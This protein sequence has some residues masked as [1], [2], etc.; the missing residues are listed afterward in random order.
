MNKNILL[1]LALSWI[2]VG[3]TSSP[4]R[5]GAMF[6]E[7][8]ALSVPGC[9][10]YVGIINCEGD[11]NDPQVTID[12]DAFTVKP[13]CIKAKK[14]KRITFT[15]K[16][17]GKIEKASV[18]VFPKAP[19]EYFWLARTNSPNKNKIRVPVPTKKNKSEDPFPPGTYKYGVWTAAQCLDPR[20]K[21]EN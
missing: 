21:V 10:P 14:G 19:P 16:S 4:P 18:V 17:N 1:P 12:L 9:A 20:V 13:M 8:G 6:G 5:D 3:C 7:F 15:L 2:I 11:K